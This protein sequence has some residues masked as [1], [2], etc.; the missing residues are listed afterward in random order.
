MIE[1]QVL[2]LD[3]GNHRLIRYGL[4]LVLWCGQINTWELGDFRGCIYISTKLASFFP[5]SNIGFSSFKYVVKIRVF[6]PFIR[7]SPP[8]YICAFSPSKYVRFPNYICA[9]SPSICVHYMCVSPF[10]YVHFPHLHMCISRIYICVCVCVF[11]YLYPATCGLKGHGSGSAAALEQ[12][13]SLF[14]YITF[15]PWHQYRPSRS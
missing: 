14:T 7:V 4:L 15:F 1:V 8:I 13:Q 5:N 10:I 6:S 2:E 3:L 12:R 11:L 9:F